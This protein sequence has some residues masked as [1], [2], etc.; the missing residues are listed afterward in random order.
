MARKVD[1]TDIR[2]IEVWYKRYQEWVKAGRKPKHTKEEKDA[3]YKECKVGIYRDWQFSEKRYKEIVDSCQQDNKDK[4]K[5]KVYSWIKS[6]KPE[7]VD[8]SWEQIV[9]LNLHKEMYTGAIRGKGR[10]THLKEQVPDL[11]Y[12]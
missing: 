1:P 8:I 5:D 9:E 2:G 12:M 6:H 10:L 4:Y 7:L 11:E 3:I